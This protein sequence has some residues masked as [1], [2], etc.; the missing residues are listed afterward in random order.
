M[1]NVLAFIFYP[2]LLY[3]SDVNVKFEQKGS[4]GLTCGPF[5]LCRHIS[6]LQTCC[7]LPAKRK[8]RTVVSSQRSLKRYLS[9]SV[10][11][12]AVR[13]WR[14]SP[15]FWVFLSCKVVITPGEPTTSYGFH[16]SPS[17][18]SPSTHLNKGGLIRLVDHCPT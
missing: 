18:S 10:R 1:G 8:S 15:M 4:T 16:S 7:H 9:R 2:V 3:I 17:P 5:L 13:C 12:S 11:D 6:V 14:K